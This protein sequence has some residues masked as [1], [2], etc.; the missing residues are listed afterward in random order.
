MIDEDAKAALDEH[1]EWLDKNAK[2][3]LPA[4]ELPKA[5][6]HGYFVAP[7]FYEIKLAKPTRIARI[8]ARSSTSSA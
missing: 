2:T 3:D 6:A 5:A 1:L 8:S 7:A 4:C